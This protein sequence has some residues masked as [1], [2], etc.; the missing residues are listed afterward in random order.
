M[1]KV[2]IK[3]NNF[4]ELYMIINLSNVKMIPE[5]KRFMI[6]KISQIDLNFKFSKYH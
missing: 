6:F 4:P 5:N 2:I 3:E 1:K